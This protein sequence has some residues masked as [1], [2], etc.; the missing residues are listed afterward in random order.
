MPT[1][2]AIKTEVF[3][4][5]L[6]LLLDLIEKRKLLINDIS[7]ASVTDEYISHVRSLQESHLTETAQFVLV[8]ATLLLIKSKS[9]L[10]VLELTE[11]ES[12]SVEDLEHRLRLYQF[13]RNGGLALNELFDVSPLHEKTYVPDTTPI[14]TTDSR[15]TVTSLHSALQDVIHRFPKKIVTPQVAVKKV[16]SLEDMMRSVEDRIQKHFKFSFKDFVASKERAHVIVGFL[17][18][19]ELFKQGSILVQQ[20]KHFHDITIERGTIDTPKY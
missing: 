17:A 18:V 12:H 20:E 4:G 14:F 15:T 2:F 16:I 5:P 8:A 3:E 19:L 11:D 7:L 10:P 6:E 13:Y 1:S 9:L